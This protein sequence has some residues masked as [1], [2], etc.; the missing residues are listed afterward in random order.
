[1]NLKEALKIADDLVFAKTGKH[2]DNL[3]QAILRGTLQG[4]KYKEI[5]K[6]LDKSEGYVRETGSQLWQMLSE[7]LGEDVNKTNFPALIERLQVSIVSHLE[8][9]HNQIGS[10]NICGE[11]SHSPNIPNSNLL[12]EETSN[13]KPTKN[14]HQDLSE[15]PELGAFYDRTPELETLTTWILQQS[16]RL[17]ALTGIS[18]I[19]KTTLA[20]QLVQQIK[21]EFEYVIWCSLEASPTLAE[22]QD[23]LIQFFSQSEKQDSPATNHKQLPLIKYLQKHRC[24]AVL[25]DVHNLFCS[26]ELA[27]KYKPGYEEYRSLFKQIEKLSH[28]CCFLLI[29]WEQPR[30]IPQVKSQNTSIRTLQLKGLDIAA[31]REILREYGLEESSA[32]IQRYQGNPL[33]LKSVATQIIELGE[34]VTEL[35][36]ND[37]ILLPEDLK[38]ILEEQCDRLS[39]IEKQVLSLLAQESDPVNL[40]KLLE[41]GQILSSDLLNALQSLTRRCLIEKQETFYTLPPVLKQYIKTL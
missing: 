30:E 10:F 4:E 20:A 25:D 14:I 40:A 36:P 12:N 6:H 9:H 28:P 26:G 22:F 41:T 8:Q 39:E 16:C 18:G 3:Q 31:A 13:T 11:T 2:L 1:M 29:G 37:T 5:A 24:L 38:D 33:W 7:L 15:M 21:D 27:G 19:G 23:K 17:I 34:S 35:L 32:L